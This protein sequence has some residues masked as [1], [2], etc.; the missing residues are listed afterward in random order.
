MWEAHLLDPAHTRKLR[1]AAYSQALEDGS[2]DKFGVVI[3]PADLDL[4]IIDLS[5]LSSWPTRENVFYIRLEEGEAR[6][7]TIRLTS[8]LG[9]LA[10]F[11]EAK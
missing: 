8:R 11:R 5:T 1:L 2:R 6:L 9:S 4:G 7:A 3:M 10:A